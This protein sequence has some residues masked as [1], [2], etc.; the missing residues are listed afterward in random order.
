ML[1]DFGSPLISLA[2][3]L[4]TIGIVVVVHEFGHYLV[5]RV[6]GIGV[7]VFS[8]GFGKEVISWRDRNQ[9]LWKICIIPLG[10]YVAFHEPASSGEQIMDAKLHSRRNGASDG[11][12]TNAS[13]RCRVMTVVAGP[14]ANFLL[15][16]V[17]FAVVA[18]ISG[19]PENRTEIA[20][21][22]PFPGPQLEFR[23][24]DTI[25]GINGQPIQDLASLYLYARVADPREPSI[26]TVKRGDGQT[27][28]IGPFPMP[29]ILEDVRPMSAASDAG[30]APG[31]VLLRVDGIPIASFLE[32]RDIVLASG[33][34]TLS[35]DV[36]R[37]GDILNI[38]LAGRYE[39]VPAAD[40]GFENR[41]MVGVSSGLFFKPLDYIPTP[42]EAIWLG[43]VQTFSII[44]F[45][46]DGLANIALGSIS[47]CNIQGPVSIAKLS[48]EAA[49]QGVVEFFTLLGILSA[50]IG[51][52]N[53]LPI[54]VLDG[55]HLVFFAYEAASGKP[56][57]ER[58]RRIATQLGLLAVLAL[59]ILGV[60]N[61]FTC[62]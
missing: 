42:F 7:R 44:A 43:G 11:T 31:D 18:G 23:T 36:W 4:V 25:V 45:S 57:G 60:F 20:S 16:I 34:K 54:P 27:E 61:D 55:G 3:F 17:I 53:L 30:L 14:V 21:V 37:G 39:D 51:F 22:K 40:G 24:G 62:P 19:F 41:L 52:M 32:F 9:T 6:S 59:L 29:P 33:G 2:A 10:G 58:V 1:P 35:L 47:V 13:L 12:F 26:Y 48:G 38:N 56:P 28:I 15:S 49:S 5:A 8:I 50:V 46:L